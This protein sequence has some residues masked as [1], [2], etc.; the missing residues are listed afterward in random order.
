M[1]CGCRGWD[2]FVAEKLDIRTL[3][4]IRSAARIGESDDWEFKS[5]KG[6]LPSSLW[7]TYSAMANSAGGTIVLGASEREG[8]VSL[9]GV[10]RPQLDMLEKSLWDQLNNRQKVNRNILASGEVHEL[11]VDGAWLLAI[12]VRSA[13]RRERPIYVGQNPFGGTFKRRH[14]GD[15]RC[16]D[17]EVRRMFADASDL[18]AD[19]RVLGGFGLDDLDGASI[20]GFRN[21][22]AASRPNHPWLAL[23]D[24]H[25]L[26]QLGGWRK[27][28]ENG[29]EGIT[30]AGLVMLG[31]HQAI[32]SPGAA[33]SYMVDFRDFRGRRRPQD[34]WSD[35]LF[36]DGTWEAN[37]FQ[38]YQRC[39]PKLVADLK[40][41]FAMKDGQ[42]ID[43]PPVNVALREALVNAMIHTDYTVGG[44]IVIERYDDRYQFANPGTLLVSEAQLRQGG[45]SQCRNRS[46]QRM[47]MLIG[48]GEQAGSG[49]ARIQE[50]WKSQHWRAPRLFAQDGPDRVRLDM[51][52]VSLMPEWAFD[53]LR[54]KIGSVLDGLDDRERAV[55]ATALIE[56]EVTNI[57]MQDLV[58]DH[59][60]DITRLLRG[61]V[62]KG[63]LE[64]DNQRRWTRYRLPATVVPRQDLLSAV[65][66][67]GGGA[68]SLRSGGNSSPLPQD[69]SPLASDSSPSGSKGEE[70]PTKGEEWKAAAARVAGKG[71]APKEEMEATVLQLCRGR[72]QTL[73]ELS[74]LLNRAPTSLRNKTLTPMLRAG[75]LR[76]RY[77]N[78]PNRPDQAYTAADGL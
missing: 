23:D 14:E 66:P 45:V 58:S 33:P 69:S 37:L 47:F 26:E 15:Y 8:T 52:M 62:A 77:P 73:A 24:K 36:P 12:H 20:S 35:R 29:K 44:G 61:L 43:D 32:I 46:L 38:F 74:V 31:K 71:K 63:L 56:D 27:D 4:E 50:G 59:S 25:L 3:E 28:R 9:D 22:F 65:T 67:M 18:P 54:Q 2:E 64:T 78:A 16:P 1:A 5:A 55:L 10:T 48:G 7:E 75:R 19:A 60:S 49:Y 53:F 76:Y 17:E 30:L 72:Y 68:G 51:P 13:E 6:G 41:P 21:R 40:V 34:R 11:D 70:M 39:W 42:R 57:R